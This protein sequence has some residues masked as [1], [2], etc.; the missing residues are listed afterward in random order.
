[1]GCRRTSA[2]PPVATLVCLWSTGTC[3]SS[4]TTM[5]AFPH[6]D[7]LARMAAQFAADP[8]L[9]MIQP[10][11]VDPDGREAPRRWTPRVRVGD[12]AGAARR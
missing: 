10:R 8:E 2:F 3:C 5:P 7:I 6:D 12:P 9:G 1:M 4:S 11:V